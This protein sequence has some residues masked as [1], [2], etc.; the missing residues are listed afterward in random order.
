MSERDE[1]ELVYGD[2]IRAIRSAADQG[3]TPSFDPEDARKGALAQRRRRL[4][5]WA[6]PAALVVIVVSC[7]AGLISFNRGSDKASTSLGMAPACGPPA[8]AT[9]VDSPGERGNDG[10]PIVAS[11][12]SISIM[13]SLQSLREGPTIHDFS[14]ILGAPGSIATAGDDDPSLP[15]GAIVKK[16]NQLAVADDP[17]PTTGS[18]GSVSLKA[19]GLAAGNY[20]VFAELTYSD[21]APCN[22]VQLE[23]VS[24]VGKIA[25][26]VVTAG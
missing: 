15:S 16:S 21:N 17:T 2:T 3:A 23:D 18:D 8:D 7:T 12:G 4:R 11:T 9:L 19:T 25:T 20:P 6:L 1:V 22:G 14:V 5:L 24:L 26:V 13:A 10:L